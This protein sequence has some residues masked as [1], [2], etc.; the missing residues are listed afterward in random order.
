MPSSRHEE[1]AR[2][3]A[4][5][6]GISIEMARNVVHNVV[7]ADAVSPYVHYTNTSYPSSDTLNDMNPHDSKF[8]EKIKKETKKR[9]LSREER[10]RLHKPLS[11]ILPDE[12]PRRAVDLKFDDIVSSIS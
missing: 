5:S 12:I 7:S 6:A 1:R 4:A 9:H 3:L 8:K 11:D 2:R 10:Q